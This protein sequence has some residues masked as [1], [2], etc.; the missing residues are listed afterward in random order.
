MSEGN[1]KPNAATDAGQGD[2]SFFE[3]GEK[4]ALKSTF[5]ARSTMEPMARNMANDGL[6]MTQLNRFF[7]H[8]RQIEFRLKRGETAWE[9]EKSEVELLSAHAADA[10]AKAEK[11]PD[12]FRQ[13]IDSNVNRIRTEE[14]FV[15]GFMKH[16][17][18]LMGFAS[19]YAK[20]GQRGRNQ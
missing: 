2:D 13:F 11:I 16:F 10:S 3:K 17:E 18:A 19:L 6:N 4:R 7:R 8:C 12:S 5:V 15:K 14:D 1:N 20:K 9:Q